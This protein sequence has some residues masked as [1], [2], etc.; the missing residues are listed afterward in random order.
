VLGGPLTALHHLVAL[1]ARDPIHPALASGEI[2]TT[3]TLTRVPPI[4]PGETWTTALTGLAL[5][6]IAVRFT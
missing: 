2:V 3:G 4:A 1:P 5:G 6:N